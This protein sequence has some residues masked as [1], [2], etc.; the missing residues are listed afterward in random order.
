MRQFLQNVLFVFGEKREKRFW[1]FI[2]IF[3][4][5]SFIILSENVPHFAIYTGIH[6]CKVD[7]QSITVCNFNQV[8]DCADCI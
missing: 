8:A 4:F 7:V 2:A 5:L 6:K 3:G 1:I